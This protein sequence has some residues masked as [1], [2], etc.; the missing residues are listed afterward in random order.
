[1]IS[2]YRIRL[3]VHKDGIQCTLCAA[4]GDTARRIEARFF[5]G[6]KPMQIPSDGYAVFSAEKPDGRVV[7]NDCII[8]D[9]GTV[10]YDFTEQTVSV[11]GR[12]VCSLILYDREGHVLASPIFVVAVRDQV[13]SEGDL[14]SVDEYLSLTK[15]YSE[16]LELS[17]GLSKV[18]QTVTYDYPED[19]SSAVIAQC[20]SDDPVIRTFR[21]V[22]VAG[23]RRAEYFIGGNTSDNKN[24][25]ANKSVITVFKEI[26]DAGRVVGHYFAPD[27]EIRAVFVQV[28]GSF[29]VYDYSYPIRFPEAGIYLFDSVGMY[30][31]YRTLSLTGP[32]LILADEVFLE[33]GRTVEEAIARLQLPPDTTLTKSGYAADAAAVGVSIG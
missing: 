7:Y 5:D 25:T 19:D 28:A 2:I 1:M 29:Y 3:N 24:G 16:L 17:V 26:T 22:K 12:T 13:V 33:D 15:L 27:G 32:S 21:L 14:T 9:D 23:Y 8:R 31:G 11:P 30:Y 4:K 6:A 10:V 20:E 18:A